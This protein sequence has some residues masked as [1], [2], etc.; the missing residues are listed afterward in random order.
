M[1]C[2]RDSGSERE[3]AQ[4]HSEV[5]APSALVAARPSLPAPPRS[6][7]QALLQPV[8]LPPVLSALSLALSGQGLPGQLLT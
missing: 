1:L 2:D 6:S 4:G 7:S 3:E 8:R 5:Q